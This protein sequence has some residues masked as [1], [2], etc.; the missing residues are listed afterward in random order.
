MLNE[1]YIKTLE[2][3]S[4]FNITI[5]EKNYILDKFNYIL[6]SCD[7]LALL[8]KIE[9]TSFNNIEEEII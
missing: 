1:E 3:C 5:E 2:D 6:K 4:K 8:P 9:T 7:K